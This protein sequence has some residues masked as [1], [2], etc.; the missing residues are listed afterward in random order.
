MKQK[1]QKIK[2]FASVFWNRL[3]ELFTIVSAYLII[4]NINLNEF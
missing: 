4:I 2:P 1:R 3:Q